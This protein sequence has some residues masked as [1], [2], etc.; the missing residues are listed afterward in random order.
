[1]AAKTFWMAY[2][3]ELA[4]SRAYR[5]EEQ[6][7]RWLLVNHLLTGGIKPLSSNLIHGNVEDRTDDAV[8]ECFFEEGADLKMPCAIH[9]DHYYIRRAEASG[10]L[11][12]AK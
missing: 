9:L 3:V 2:R 11:S 1:M 7:E 5:F 12:W 6:S 8:K 10:Q 4:G